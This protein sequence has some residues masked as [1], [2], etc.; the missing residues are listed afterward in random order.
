MALSEEFKQRGLCTK[1]T[2]LQHHERLS[3]AVFF[4]ENLLP[5]IR[6][7]SLPSPSSTL[8]FCLLMKFACVLLCLKLCSRCCSIK[9]YRIKPSYWTTMKLST[10]LVLLATGTTNAFVVV[11]SST[12]ISSS[13]ALKAEI[14]PP[15]PKN[16]V[17][18]FGWDGTTALGGA[19]DNSQP[20]R[21]LDEIRA[22]G[23]TQNSACDLF[24][25]NLGEWMY[26]YSERVMHN[27]YVL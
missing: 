14:R 12:S 19:V 25:A 15:T 4:I 24:N 7:T 26:M 2:N 13:T 11:P 23:E 22:S 9:K 1:Y 3:L 18:E 17:L 16:E 21:M 27:M 5:T 10:A 8:H 20:A 6:Y